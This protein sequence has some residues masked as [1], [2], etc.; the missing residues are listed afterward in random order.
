MSQGKL[1][2]HIP[3]EQETTTSPGGSLENGAFKPERPNLE[4][5]P[6]VLKLDSVSKRFASY[7]SSFHRF[8]HW[9]GLPVRPAAAIE[10]IQ[11]TSFEVRRGEAV[12]LIGQNGAGKSTLL[13]L[14][15]GTMK[16]TTGR[17]DHVPSVS[18]ILELGLGFNPEFTG[19]ENVVHS[20][21]MM[22]HSPAELQAIMPGIETFAEIGT[23][24]DKPLRTYSSGMQARLAFSLATAVQPEI[25]I[26]DEVLSVGDAYFQ[27]KS[28]A[29]IREFRDKG[30]TIFLV[31]HSLGDVR[32]LC[33]RVLLLDKGAIARDGEPDE[34]IDYYNVLITEKQNALLSVEQRRDKQG[35]SVTRSGDFRA[36]V[37]EIT[38]LSAS[39]G[40]EIATARA[41]ER[42]ILRTEVEVHEGVEKL[43]L[44]LM[45][46]NRTGH[47]V[48][49]TNTWHTHQVIDNVKAGERVTFV[50]EF[51]C[52]L[53]PDS[54]S[55]SPALVSSNTHLDDNY[56][57]VDN[58]FVFD[59]VNTTKDFFIG[60]TL[61][62]GAFT[63]E[64]AQVK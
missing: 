45:I 35:W 13:K 36:V 1:I 22:G 37:R 59:V 26:V 21:G 19:R 39:T 44:G 18:A 25:L 30:C 49:G 42:V 57:W 64:R 46:R 54:Y 38:L 41:G 48:W 23:F 15:T 10:V 8:C 3:H 61:L 12:A 50:Y 14:I 31:T 24:F 4:T 51:D 17:I 33:D 53:G 47:V 2:S 28:F 52:N 58:L 40:A 11:K 20:G 62:D 34:V 5:A 43:V 29:R 16:P 56:E 63:I 55:I 32:E 27:H 9:M 7:S 60:T 6:V